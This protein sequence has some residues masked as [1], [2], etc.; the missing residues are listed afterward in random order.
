MYRSNDRP[1]KTKECLPGN[2]FGNWLFQSGGC[3]HTTMLIY[4]RPSEFQ[5]KLREECAV[6]GSEKCIFGNISGLRVVHTPLVDRE[7]VCTEDLSGPFLPAQ[8][9]SFV[10]LGTGITG[11]SYPCSSYWPP[12]YEGFPVPPPMDYGT[13]R[14][15]ITVIQYLSK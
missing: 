3:A 12:I 9:R 7:G 4:L 2:L 15:T 5:D 8:I 10:P 6:P 14:V 1:F 13:R 11:V